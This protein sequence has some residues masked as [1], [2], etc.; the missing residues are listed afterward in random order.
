M[1]ARLTPG[2]RAP[3]T[4]QRSRATRHLHPIGEPRSPR[5][6]PPFTSCSVQSGTVEPDDDRTWFGDVGQGRG[7]SV[8]HGSSCSSSCPLARPARTGPA[9]AG[10]R[11]RRCAA[12]SARGSDAA[13]R[14]PRQRVHLR[15]HVSCTAR[16]SPARV[17]T[18]RLDDVALPPP[19]LT[20][21]LGAHVRSSRAPARPERRLGT[22]APKGRSAAATPE[23]TMPRVRTADTGHR[24]HVP[25]DLRDQASA[26]PCI[27]RERN[28]IMPPI[29]AAVPTASAGIGNSGT[30]AGG[31]ASTP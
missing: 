1:T 2:R 28:A 4:R 22:R 31:V 27:R 12:T 14:S 13:R 20:R 10:T 15:P 16:N 30:S 8:A 25:Q 18:A 21:S 6:C 26:L 24:T 29:T 9:S 7:R 3:D 5:R 11:L 23:A 19:R 17:R